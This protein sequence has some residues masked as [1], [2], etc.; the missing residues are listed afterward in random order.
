MDWPIGS[1]ALEK[2]PPCTQERKAIP[3][4]PEWIP[5]PGS[6]WAHFCR[7]P[8]SAR[9]C[10]T[11]MPFMPGLALTSDSGGGL[12]TKSTG[13]QS[14]CPNI[15]AVTVHFVDSWAAV[16][17]AHRTKGWCKSQFRWRNVPLVLRSG[18]ATVLSENLFYAQVLADLTDHASFK[19]R[20]VVSVQLL[21]HTETA[22]HFTG[23]ALSRGGSPPVA[24]R[25]CIWPVSK[26]V[27]E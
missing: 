4:H 13:V 19:I 27:H 21:R 25:M 11:I 17:Y 2:P 22:E 20:S 14:S 24:D 10:L 7:A 18:D 23:Q 9:A 5:L 6:E 1:S 3:V 15:R 8:V 12:N 26:E 16:W